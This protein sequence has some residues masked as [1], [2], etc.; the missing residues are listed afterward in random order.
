MYYNDGSPSYYEIEYGPVGFTLGNGTRVNTNTQFSSN[1]LTVNGMQHSTTYDFYVRA[2]CNSSAPTDTSNFIKYT[3]T[4][5]GSCPKPHGLN[6][7]VIS[8]ACNVGS[9]ATRVM[10]WHYDYGTPSSYTVCIVQQGD[11]P[12]ATAN[13]YTTMNNSI[14]ISGMYCLWKAFYVR[15]NCQNGDSSDWAGPYYF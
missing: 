14:A 12:S 5:V 13:A 3:Y 11:Q 9:G 8:G 4:T 1:Y 10:S 7:D 15:A 2:V 6:S